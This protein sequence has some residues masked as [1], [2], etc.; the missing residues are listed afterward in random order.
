M[1]PRS[2]KDYTAHVIEHTIDRT[3]KHA[4]FRI[5]DSEYR[6]YGYTNGRARTVRMEMRRWAW[7]EVRVSGD[8]AKALL[9][10]FNEVMAEDGVVYR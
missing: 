7:T 4:M 5:G 1:K 6:V 9:K 8:F 10:A 3:F 2:P